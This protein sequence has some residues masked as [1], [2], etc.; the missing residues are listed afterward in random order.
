M[1]GWNLLMFTYPGFIIL[2]ETI[3]HIIKR[4]QLKKCGKTI[5]YLEMFERV[6]SPAVLI[7]L[8]IAFF[9]SG[10]NMT[11]KEQLQEFVTKNNLM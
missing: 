11:E 4:Q 6:I 9:V 2:Q 1:D 5:K 10:F 7:I 8:N 3:I